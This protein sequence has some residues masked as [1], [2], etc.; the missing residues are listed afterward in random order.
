MRKY[1]YIYTATLMESLQYVM[2]ILLG[3]ITFF[4]ILYVFINLWEYLYSDPKA[5]ISGYSLPQMIWYVI[6]TEIMWFGIRNRTLTA[7]MSTDIKSG[8]IAYGIN[9]PYH[10][11]FYIISKYL[12][13]ITLQFLLFFSAGVILGLL[14]IGGIPQFDIRQ[15]PFALLSFFLGIMIN[16]AICLGIGSLSFWI[17]DS[18]PLRWIY[19][20]MIIVIGTL[21]PMEL[22]PSWLQPVIKVS[23]IYVINYGPA[24]LMVDFSY[25]AAGKVI[26]MQL[27]Y[28]AG[29]A[30]LLSIIFQKGVR[31]LNV[32]GG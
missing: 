2:N 9:K 3:F 16:A 19:D 15:L 12:G 23:P 29:T 22:F 28:M 20:K 25:A 6:L 14:F 21:F 17:E 27:V 18:T 31:K 7:Q 26:L 13:E 4:V 5:L 8:T 1:R 10:Y 11:V 24:K 32:N 30:I